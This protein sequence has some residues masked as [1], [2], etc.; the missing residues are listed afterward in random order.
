MKKRTKIILIILILIIAIIVF[1]LSKNPLAKEIVDIG[2]NTKA[3]IEVKLSKEYKEMD[4]DKYYY[5][6]EK[7]IRIPILIYHEIPEKNPSRDLFYMQT[8]AQQFEKQIKGMLNEGYEFISYEDLISYYNGEKAL[9]QK[10]VLI[11]FDDGWE[12]NYTNAFPILK[13]YNIP[14]AIYVVDDLV[15]TPGY[16]TWKQ[17]KEMSDSGLISIYSHGRSHIKYDKE[18]VDTLVTDVNIAY[19]NIEEHVGKKNHR[20]FTYPYGLYTEEGIKALAEEGYVQNLTDDEINKSNQLDLS[21]LHRI[22][23]QQNYSAYKIIKN[24]NRINLPE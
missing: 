23:V 24:I 11:G 12:D 9:K 5:K 4:D 16:F 14:A 7:D 3:Y 18:S 21:R 2:R 22:Y 19:D 1:F 15:G 10:T 13:K 20:V 8:T 17:A 6:N